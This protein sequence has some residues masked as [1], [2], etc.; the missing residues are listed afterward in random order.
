MTNDAGATAEGVPARRSQDQ[1]HNV[2]GPSVA[3]QESLRIAR[4]RDPDRNNLVFIDEDE[5]K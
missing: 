4:L 1:G 3:E 5:K 2:E